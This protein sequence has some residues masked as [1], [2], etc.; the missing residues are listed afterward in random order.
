MKCLSRQDL[1]LRP[2]DDERWDVMHDMVYDELIQAIL[3]VIHKLDFS[4]TKDPD[5][6]VV[7]KTPECPC[8][9]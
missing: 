2:G 8:A 5:L 3:R 9:V 4:F 7:F 1:R 6:Q